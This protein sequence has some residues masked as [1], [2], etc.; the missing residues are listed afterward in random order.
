[1]AGKRVAL[2]HVIECRL[3]LVLRH[4]PRNERPLRQI[5][6]QQWMAQALGHSVAGELAAGGSAFLRGLLDAVAQARRVRL[7][8]LDRQP[9]TG[10]HRR[11][12]TSL[13]TASID[14]AA[15]NVIRSWCLTKQTQLLIGF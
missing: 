3:E 7:V 4:L 12:V 13:A 2:K 5:R 8:Y 10:R 6:R 14:P 15:A 11:V 9:R 1:M